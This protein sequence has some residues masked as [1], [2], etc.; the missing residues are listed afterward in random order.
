MGKEVVSGLW[1]VENMKPLAVF[2]S[3]VSSAIVVPCPPSQSDRECPTSY[4][5]RQE[6]PT[7]YH[8]TPIRGQML[9]SGQVLHCGFRAVQT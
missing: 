7:S 3:V 5:V 8:H 6:C 9:P 1:L 2:S 4:I